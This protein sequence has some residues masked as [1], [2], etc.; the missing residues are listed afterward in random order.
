MSRDLQVT[1]DLVI[2]FSLGIHIVDHAGYANR[3]ISILGNRIDTDSGGGRG[4]HRGVR[5][6]ASLV[7]AA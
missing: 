2:D 1:A 4:I 7:L 6:F 3:R 5:L